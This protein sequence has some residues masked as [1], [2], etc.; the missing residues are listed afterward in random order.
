MKTLMIPLEDSEYKTLVKAKGE[1]TWK[2][3]LFDRMERR[4]DENNK[5]GRKF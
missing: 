1:R 5:Q 3:Y 2:Q 4:E